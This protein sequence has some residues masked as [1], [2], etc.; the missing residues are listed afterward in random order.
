MVA[1]LPARAM[2]MV[3]LQR[4]DRLSYEQK[5]IEYTCLKRAVKAASGIAHEASSNR[6]KEV[7]TQRTRE[8]NLNA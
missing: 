2:S 8:Q 1:L 7:K 5:M 6:L 3:I 4:A